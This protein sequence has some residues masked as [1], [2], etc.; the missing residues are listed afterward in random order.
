MKNRDSFKEPYLIKQINSNPTNIKDNYADLLVDNTEKRHCYC[1]ERPT[2]RPA[3]Y[4]HP[5]G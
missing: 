5:A 1:V 3:G 2:N 4:T